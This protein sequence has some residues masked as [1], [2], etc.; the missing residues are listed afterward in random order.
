[1]QSRLQSFA[2][3]TRSLDAYFVTT[4]L[5]ACSLTPLLQNAAATDPH[6]PLFH[7]TPPSQ[8]MND[9]NGMVYFEGEYHLFYQHHPESTVW[10]PMHWGH[11]VSTDLINWQH[12]PIALFPDA[13]GT[14]FSGS[15]V[16]DWNNTSGFGTNGKPPL[17][18][19][20]TN[21]NATQEAAGREDFQTQGL[22]YSNDRGRTWTKFA[23][24]PVLPNANSIKDFRDPKVVWHATT[25]S[26]V[27]A[28]AAKD[29]IQFWRSPNLKNWEMA[30]EF[31]ASAGAHTGVWECP[32]IFELNIT[33]TIEKRWVLLVSIN[34]GGPNGGSATQY[35]VGDFDGNVFKESSE[36]AGQTLWLDH[37][38]DNYAGVTFCDIPTNDGRRIFVGWMS[39]WD[40]AKVV[41]TEK[42][43]SALTLPRTLALARTRGGLRVT[44]APVREFARLRATTTA[45]QTQSVSSALTL[46]ATHAHALE[47]ELEITWTNAPADFAI[48]L[49]NTKGEIYALRFDSA[50]NQF[51]SDRSKAGRNDFSPAFVPKQAT[52]PRA[53][54]ACAM[55]LHLICDRASCEVFTDDGETCLTEIF[56]PSEDFVTA[57]LVT[58][59]AAPIVIGSGAVHELRAATIA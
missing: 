28:L 36:T 8:W 25:Q 30:S 55:K 54:N 21:H 56:F 59:G 2:L 34:P 38:R 3:L 39:N 57:K 5:A 20:F 31:G 22:A 17:V 11:A 58:L 42:W 24:N 10:G 23:G 9:P 41:P 48:E 7:F 19:I 49:A 14:I 43:R 35:F 45:L 6:R 32:D 53:R 46:A 27:M 47:I 33:D 4:A 13:L 50:T 1:L 44:S 18:A 52:A 15:A 40:Y 37:G 26:W 29:R 12:L 51:F 16:V